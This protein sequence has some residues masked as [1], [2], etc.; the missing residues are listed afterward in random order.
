MNTAELVAQAMAG[1]PSPSSATQPLTSET[2]PPSA[3]TPQPPPSDNGSAS[4]KTLTTYLSERESPEFRK[5]VLG[6]DEETPGARKIA[7]YAERWIKAAATN[8]PAAKSRW[9]VLAGATGVGK[10][11]ALRRAY[12]FLRN[13][14]GDLWPRPY[15]MPPGVVCYTWSRIVGL[16]PMSWDDIEVEAQRARMV[17]VD[18]MGSETDRFRTGEPVERLRTLLDVCAGKWL[19]VT[20]NVPKAKFLDVFDA[21]VASRLERAVVLDLVGVPDYRPRLIKDTEQ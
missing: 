20:T 21:R 11:H 17:L 10:T 15:A 7:R 1:L 14:S 12:A 18:D 3:P 2:S 19:L 5:L 8:D 9:L 4:K 16:G 6:M 13:H